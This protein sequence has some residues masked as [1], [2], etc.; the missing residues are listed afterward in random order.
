MVFAGFALVVGLM[1]D[2]YA[3]WL[4]NEK[5]GVQKFLAPFLAT[6]IQ[7]FALLVIVAYRGLAPN[8]L[9]TPS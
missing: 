2:R 5:D 9:A 4:A 1:S 7:V 3:L 6:G 8:S